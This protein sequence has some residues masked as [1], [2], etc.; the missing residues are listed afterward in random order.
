MLPSYYGERY[1][2]G[3]VVEDGRQLYVTTGF[4]TTG[5]P[6]RLLAPPEVVILRLT[7]AA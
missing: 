7:G 6:V 1:A 3:H 4:G 2:R 5:W